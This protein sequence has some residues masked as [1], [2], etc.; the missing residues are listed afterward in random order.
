MARLRSETTNDG[1]GSA[2]SENKRKKP[3]F[4]VYRNADGS[5]DTE[6]LSDADRAAF[7]AHTS[8]ATNAAPPP[9][10]A[11]PAEPMPDPIDPMIIG[12][13]LN[14]LV[15]IESAVVG[16]KLGIPQQTAFKVLTPKPPFDESI[17]ALATKVANKYGA[18]LG[19]YS[20]EIALVA[21]IGAWQVSAFSELRAIVAEQAARKPQDAP[22][23]RDAD[24]HQSPPPDAPK[25]APAPEKAPTA[26]PGGNVVPIDLLLGAHAATGHAAQGY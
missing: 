6:H 7:N 2:S 13:A 26:A 23:D 5:F 10:A 15:S 1:P 19:P 8:G 18:S 20:D 25:P 21:L 4:T 12:M 14:L 24:R 17:T 16:Q 11:G 9:P 3:R 22:K